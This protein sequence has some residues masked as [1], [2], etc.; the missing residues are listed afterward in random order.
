MIPQPGAAISGL[1]PD[2][3]WW[4]LGCYKVAARPVR[5][6]PTI[7]IC[8]SCSVGWGPGGKFLY[9]W[10]RSLGEMGGGSTIVIGLP[11]GEEMPKLPAQG[12]KSAND[13]KGLNVVAEIDMK[14]I[15]VFAPGPNPSIYAYVRTSVQR[16]LFRIPLI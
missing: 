4:L 5:G 10:L 3:D 9:V 6:G 2:G 11:P 12:L 7:R 8:D 14:G 1:S 16:N 13:V 15:R